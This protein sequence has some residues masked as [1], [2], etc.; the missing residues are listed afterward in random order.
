MNDFQR[1]FNSYENDLD[2]VQ[3]I[4]INADD[5]EARRVSTDCYNLVREI[6][7]D[8]AAN[9]FGD[10]TAFMENRK[11]AIKKLGFENMAAD[12]ID[13]SSTQQ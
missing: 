7:K 8:I 2:V 5:R 3:D 13:K 1:F 11:R 10:L 9:R 4:L 6:D 12:L